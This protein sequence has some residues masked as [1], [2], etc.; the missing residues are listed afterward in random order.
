MYGVSVSLVSP[1]PWRS[2]VKQS[3]P[4]SDARKACIVI[5]WY[6]EIFDQPVLPT[7]DNI[8]KNIT[9]LGCEC[10]WNGFMWFRIYDGLL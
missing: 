6:I 4:T 1:W 10:V 3:E 9:Y 5:I 7:R 8:R 2:A